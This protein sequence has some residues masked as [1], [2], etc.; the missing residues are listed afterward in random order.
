MIKLTPV[1]SDDSAYTIDSYK[2]DG[3]VINDNCYRKTLLIANNHLQCDDTLPTSVSEIQPHHI[4]QIIKLAPSIVIIGSGE[5]YHSLSVSLS[6]QLL[7]QGIGVEVMTTAAACRT[8][9]VLMAEGRT[10]VALLI[11]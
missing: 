6:Q 5:H 10:A 7:C 4:E 1:N 2:P 11:L 8:F 3:I 9:N